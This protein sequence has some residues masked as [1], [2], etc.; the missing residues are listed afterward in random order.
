MRAASISAAL[1]A[2]ALAAA[3]PAPASADPP[4][5]R[6]SRPKT[7]IVSLEPRRAVIVD[8]AQLPRADLVPLAR[9]PAKP[10]RCK[11]DRRGVARCPVTH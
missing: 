11:P 2:T 8:A 3:A 7:V 9:T 10:P 4:V 6:T 1:L 5:R